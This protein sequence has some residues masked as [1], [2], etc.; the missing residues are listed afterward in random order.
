MKSPLAKNDPIFVAG[1]RGLVGSALVRA[2]QNQG[3]TNLLLRTSSELDLRDGR[4]VD[5]FFRP[6]QPV[7]ALLPAA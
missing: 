4:A 2:L 1:H 7:P 6:Q 3:F 5:A